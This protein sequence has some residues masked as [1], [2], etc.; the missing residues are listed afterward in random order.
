MSGLWS[1]FTSWISQEHLTRAGE[2]GIVFLTYLGLRVFLGRS[3]QTLV[4]QVDRRFRFLK[5]ANFALNVVLVLCLYQLWL[6]RGLGVASFVGLLSA[7]LAFVFREPLLNLAGW[8][9]IVTR[10]PFSLGDRIQVGN[11][12]AGDVID[13]GVY[14]FTLMEIGNWVDADQSTGRIIHVPNGLVFNQAIANYNQGFPFLWHELKVVLTYESDWRKASTLLQEVA[15]KNS[16]VDREERD[17]TIAELQRQENYLIYF[18]HLTP[19]VYVSKAD[20]GVLLTLR[21]LCQP[22]RRRATENRLWQDILDSFGQHEDI[23]FAYQTQRVRHDPF[24]ESTTQMG[25]REFRA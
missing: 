11:L 3:A 13:I 5:N 9:F 14:D 6:S 7:G 16:E 23:T 10:H 25:E 24:M 2:T 17:A 1:E 15:D 12:H 18:K 21:Y 8:V 4:K 19:I 22:R 20:S